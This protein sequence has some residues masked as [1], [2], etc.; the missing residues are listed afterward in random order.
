MAKGSTKYW[1]LIS[2]WKMVIVTGVCCLSCITDVPEFDVFNESKILILGYIGTHGERVKVDILKSVSINE[3]QRDHELVTNANVKLIITDLDGKV[4]EYPLFL[5]ENHYETV[6]PLIAKTGFQYALQVNLG[7]KTYQSTTL[8]LP[9]Q[10]PNIS[11][12]EIG[13]TSDDYKE[14]EISVE[15]PSEL[16]SYFI[17]LESLRGGI[18]LMDALLSE[19][20][21]DRNY[22]N[23][24][25][26]IEYV[27]YSNLPGEPLINSYVVQIPQEVDYFFRDWD[28]QANGNQNNDDFLNLVFSVPPGNLKNN[29]KNENQEVP[30][31]IIGIFFP[32]HSY[33]FE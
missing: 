30:N 18:D 14:W 12:N 23:L 1:T 31:E 24:N 2:K 8:K 9:P 4:L 11:V 22:R 29:F 19:K 33:A 15:D 26:L 32:A 21:Y 10:P 3:T 7:Q 13:L 6:T 16:Y 28:T 20:Y 25:P 17:G 5:G 27:G